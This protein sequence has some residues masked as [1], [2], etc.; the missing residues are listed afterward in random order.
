MN[1]AHM[2]RVTTRKTSRGNPRVKFPG[3]VRVASE[4][5]VTRQH[6]FEVLRGQRI[7]PNLKRAYE[8]HRR[9]TGS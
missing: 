2:S 7:S 4:Q 8:Q 1:N 3:I 5:G 9:A 6:L